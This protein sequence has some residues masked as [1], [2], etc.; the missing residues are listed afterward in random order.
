MKC[1]KCGAEISPPAVFCQSCLAEME[2]EPVD[3]DAKLVLPVRP[4]PAAEPRS[5]RAKPQFKPEEVI[6]HQR[7]LI[8]RLR[9]TAACLLALS[10]ALGTLLF[11]FGHFD[12]LPAHALGQNFKTAG[13]E[14]TAPTV[15][16][17]TQTPTEK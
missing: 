11:F 4:E 10:L 3:R 15:P 7:G 13:V 6:A 16:P 5:Q 12:E 9:I 14:T 8:R 17:S 2:R 1:L